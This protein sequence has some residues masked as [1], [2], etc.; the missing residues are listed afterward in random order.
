MIVGGVLVIASVI[1]NLITVNGPFAC[2][3]LVELFIE[4]WLFRKLIGKIM[5]C[6]DLESGL[7]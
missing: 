5:L 4:D 3:P 1:Q 2:N 7:L 6:W